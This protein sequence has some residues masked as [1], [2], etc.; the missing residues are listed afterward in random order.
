MFFPAAKILLMGLVAA[1]VIGTLHVF[2]S[3]KGFFE[4]TTRLLEAGYLTVPNSVTLPQAN[5]LVTAFAG[6]LFFTLTIGCFLSLV[7]FIYTWIWCRF[8]D[9][10]AW[11]LLPGLLI[12]ATI[13]WLLNRAVLLPMASA[14]FFFIPPIVAIATLKSWQKSPDMLHL[15][16]MMICFVPV[17]ILTVVGLATASS[18]LFINFRD[19]ILLSNPVGIKINDF[20]YKYTLYPA[21]IFKPFEKK[22]IKS[23]RLEYIDDKP[24][25]YRIERILLLY[26]YLPVAG[27]K[28]DLVLS[29]TDKQINFFHN[30]A[31]ILSVSPKEFLARPYAFFKAF[32]DKTDAFKFFRRVTFFGLLV[33]LPLCVYVIFFG[34][35]QLTVS[36]FTGRLAASISASVIC[37]ILGFGMIFLLQPRQFLENKPLAEQLMSENKFQRTAAIKEVLK[38]KLDITQYPIGEMH[39]KSAYMPERYWLAKALSVSR[40]KRAETYLLKLMDDPSVNVRC[41][42]YQALGGRKNRAY[43][44]VLMQALE[45]SNHM[46][47]QLYAYNALKELGWRQTKTH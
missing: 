15:R 38:K 14:Y 36:L 11:M 34:I 45:N 41:K 16:Q 12:W 46:Y 2:F 6:G 42:A 28:S 39:L 7:S 21:E 22:L 29:T 17:I 1:Q 24:L 19:K 20:Y 18:Q 8:F 31:L 40:R 3:N 35:L 5:T 4:Q 43:I 25:S 47:A 26:D 13:L 10:R 37:L 9:K 23:S 30:D 44:P 32:S 33:G 27:V